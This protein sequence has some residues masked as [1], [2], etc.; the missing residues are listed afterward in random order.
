ML[1]NPHEIF[2]YYSCSLIKGLTVQGIIKEAK[3][4]IDIELYL[5]NLSKEKKP[6][7]NFLWNVGKWLNK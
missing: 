2:V 6:D 3:K 7:R 5:P 1:G 4:L